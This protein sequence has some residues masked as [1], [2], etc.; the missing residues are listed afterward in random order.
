MMVMMVIQD[1]IVVQS[2]LNGRLVDLVSTKRI[3]ASHARTHACIILT[4]APTPEDRFD[5]RRPE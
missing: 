1:E 4:Q 2:R 3:D 5:A